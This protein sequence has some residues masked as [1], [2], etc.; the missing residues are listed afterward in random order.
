MTLLVVLACAT[1]SAQAVH[2]SLTHDCVP[3]LSGDCTSFDLSISP[4]GN[5]V[6]TSHRW[7]CSDGKYEGHI[8]PQDLER[9]DGLLED[10]TA[11]APE[12]PPT[13]VCMHAPA[14]WVRERLLRQAG[15]DQRF[16]TNACVRNVE[17][18]PLAQLF[19]FARVLAVRATWDTFTP[20]SPRSERPDPSKL[21]PLP[22][23]RPSP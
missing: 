14:F 10:V 3:D 22:V 7:I 6:L 1:L 17:A 4:T 16:E 5:A 18:S 20:S 9:L 2:V 21:T 15:V 19:E 23:R 12:P 8:T 11:T 13:W